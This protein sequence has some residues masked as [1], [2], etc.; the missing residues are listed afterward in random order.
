MSQDTSISRYRP[1]CHRATLLNLPLE[2]HLLIKSYLSTTSCFSLA[3]SHRTFYNSLFLLKPT[4]ITYDKEHQ[5]IRATIGYYISTIRTLDV[6]SSTRDRDQTADTRVRCRVCKQRYE[7][8]MY[9]S[10]TGTLPS[11]RANAN[12]E[13]KK[14][15]AHATTTGAMHM[16][17]P[18]RVCVWCTDKFVIAY[19]RPTSASLP[20][21]TVMQQPF[22]L[23]HGGFVGKDSGPLEHGH[24]DERYSP[25]ACADCAVVIAPQYIRWLDQNEPWTNNMGWQFF[26]R[27]G[28][29]WVREG[30]KETKVQ[31]GVRGRDEVGMH[32]WMRERHWGPFCGIVGVGG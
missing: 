21:W 5:C 24:V 32:E 3:L 27:N 19:R 10:G 17:L 11:K 4:F 18:P 16:S 23:H 12:N 20:R 2:L 26:L 28:D 15:P 14:T 7:P 30:R 6:R 31:R 1:S 25:C 22:C 9:P 13:N 8:S 29:M